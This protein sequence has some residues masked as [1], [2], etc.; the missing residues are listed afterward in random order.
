MNVVP[1]ALVT[2]VSS[3]LRGK[4]YSQNTD[5]SRGSCERAALTVILK[6]LGLPV[7]VKLIRIATSASSLGASSTRFNS[8]LLI[9]NC[10]STDELMG[11]FGYKLRKTRLSDD[12]MKVEQKLNY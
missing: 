3:F 5:L 1:W 4:L 7:L 12:G 10:E 6:R 2:I 11:R 9:K 8:S